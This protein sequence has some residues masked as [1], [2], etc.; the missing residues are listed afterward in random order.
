ML[1]PNEKGINFFTDKP[2]L[3]I[4][5]GDLINQEREIEGQTEELLLPSSAARHNTKVQTSFALELRKD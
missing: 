3:V 2:S 5:N 4:F 1:G